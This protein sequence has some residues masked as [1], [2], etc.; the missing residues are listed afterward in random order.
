LVK[1]YIMEYL[2]IRNTFQWL[3]A[4]GCFRI[5]SDSFLH[6][7]PTSPNSPLVQEHLKTRYSC[8]QAFSLDIQPEAWVQRW[9]RPH[10]YQ[11]HP[12]T[13]YWYFPWSGGPCASNRR[14]I[15]KE[16]FGW[17]QRWYDPYSH[18]SKGMRHNFAPHTTQIFRVLDLAL[19]G[20][21]RRCP[22]YELPFD[23]N[24][25]TLKVTTKVYHDFT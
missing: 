15:D 12:L 14:L 22:R 20:V 21:L 7:I 25:A 19:F 3:L 8:R 17:C 9:P 2:E 10:L 5:I 6:Y 13:I 4:C 24:N 18:W 23:E 11:N 16:L 1:R